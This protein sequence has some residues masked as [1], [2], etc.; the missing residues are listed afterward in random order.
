MRTDRAGGGGRIEWHTAVSG[1]G[2]AAPAPAQAVHAAIRALQAGDAL[3]PVT[4][5]TPSRTTGFALRRTVAALDT[6]RPGLLGVRFEVVERLAELLGAPPLQAQGRHPLSDAALTEA[7]RVALAEAGGV[8]AP[9]ADHPATLRAVRRTVQE[10]RE[11]PP[12]ELGG[13]RGPRA[14]DTLRLAARAAALLRHTYDTEDLLTAAAEAVA[15][16]PALLRDVGGVVAVVTGRLRPRVRDL[17]AALAALTDVHVVAVH[18][19][20]PDA[21]EEV[22]QAVASLR[23]A[24]HE[25]PGAADQEELPPVAS[26]AA[27]LVISAPDPDTE[28]R[29]AV[30]HVAR[31]LHEGVPLHRMALLWTDRRPYAL[32]V[33][34]ALAG[35]GLPAVGLPRPRLADSPTGRALL[36]ALR[37]AGG[38]LERDAVMHW[39]TA[40]PIRREAGGA[41]ADSARWDAVSRAAGVVRD[42]GQWRDRLDRRVFDAGWERERAEREDDV[43]AARHWTAEAEHADALRRFVDELARN[44]RPPGGQPTWGALA[45]WV[46]GLLD[47]YV[48]EPRLS[49]TDEEVEADRAVRQAVRALAALDAVAVRPGLPAFRRAVEGELERRVGGGL[50]LG[51][52]LL[53]GPLERAL[54]ADLDVVVVVGLVEG[55]APP[56]PRDD[57]VLP[58]RD[59]RAAP[60]MAL[61][62]A[63]PAARR[64]AY[65]AALGAAREHVLTTCRSDPRGGRERIPSRWLL[66]AAAAHERRPVHSE[67]LAGLR[68]RPWL[69][70]VASFPQAL[71]GPP[72]GRHDLELRVLAAGAAEGVPLHRHPGADAALTAAF[73]AVAERRDGGLS[74]WTGH[75]A[76]DAPGLGERPL[77]PTGLQTW[78]LCPFRYFLE[79]VLRVEESPR[80]EETIRIE[81]RDRGALIHEILQRFF[82]QAEHVPAPGVAWPDAERARLRA[83][84]ERECAKREQQGLTGKPLLWRLERERVLRELDAF[85]D[86]EP[87]LRAAQDTMP[88]A[89]E[90]RFG[91]TGDDAPALT[92]GAHRVAFRGM[93]D[94]VERNADG[95]RVV[96]VDY[97]TGKPERHRGALDKDPVARGQLLQLPVYA[98]A[99]MRGAPEGA[100]VRGAYW[101]LTSDGI[102]EVPWE[103]D[104]ARQEVFAGAVRVVADGIQQGLFPQRPGLDLL[105]GRENCT[106]CPHSLA[107]DSDRHRRWER[108]RAEPRLAGLAALEGGGD[109]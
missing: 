83:I 95:T 84:T 63:A 78:A 66:E 107:C 65:L 30:A 58:D 28:V 24:V 14:R 1:P 36:G 88:V 79:R 7:V 25:Q 4:V 31:R 44:L 13:L 68:D 5:L 102:T 16:D 46:V 40:A 103:A 53:T 74:P 21:D 35:A 19:G 43:A 57:S 108:L 52:G 38:A 69:R 18:A 109:D 54:C 50:R 26:P 39:L 87:G 67:E 22:R 99:A 94:R 73:R 72:A 106:G 80:P 104:E 48:G 20:D 85:L 70:W 101:F 55:V 33:R 15:A 29:A 81:P 93:I 34:D 86:D 76:A 12:E 89:A 9:V 17:L 8:F 77:S 32:L 71:A 6:E 10:L 61:R 47:R 49:W 45:A 11:V 96:V 92:A 3:R 105:L 27:E 41:E 42:L 100:R 75:V 2:R 98:L 51:Q 64:R 62:T 91:F 97:K 60:G 90:E 56:R 23:D 37:L 82:E 59:R